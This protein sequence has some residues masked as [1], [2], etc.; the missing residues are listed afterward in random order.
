M[1]NISVFLSIHLE[2]WF[3]N[4]YNAAPSRSLLSRDGFESLYPVEI[5]KSPFKGAYLL[6]GYSIALES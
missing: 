6:M 1:L 3:R 2:T 5:R 4:F